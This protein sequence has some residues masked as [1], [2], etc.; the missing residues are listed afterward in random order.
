MELTAYLHRLRESGTYYRRA[1]GLVKKLKPDPMRKNK[2]HTEADIFFHTARASSRKENQA[3]TC[4]HRVRARANGCR[5]EVD[6]A[7]PNEE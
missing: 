3:V 2:R 6:F 1:F 5:M 7:P 4:G